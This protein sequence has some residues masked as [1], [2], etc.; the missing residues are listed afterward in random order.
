M[1]KTGANYA[2]VERLQH[3][4]AARARAAGCGGR[5]LPSFF[6]CALTLQEKR[7]KKTSETKGG[8]RGQRKE[9]NLLK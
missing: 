8:Q 1:S 4:V 3:A 6:P 2:H 7:P 9:G 5:G